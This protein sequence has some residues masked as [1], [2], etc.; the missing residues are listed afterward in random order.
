MFLPPTELSLAKAYIFGDIDLVGDIEAATAV[1]DDIVAR[2]DSLGKWVKIA[3]HVMSALLTLPRPRDTDGVGRRLDAAVGYRHRHSQERDARAVRFH[4]DVGN[5]FYKLWLDKRMVYSCA[6]FQ[7]GDESLD[8]AQT[9]KL[10]Y[11]CRKLDLQAGDHLLDIGCGWGGLITFAAAHYGVNALGVTLSPPQ[12][13]IARERI[14]ATGLS[15][16]CRV[17]VRDYR[18]LRKGRQFNKIVSVGMVEHVGEDHLPEY[19]DSI[20]GMLEP[21]GLFLNHGIVTIDGARSVPRLTR[22][23]NRLWRRGAF[24]ENYVFPD[25]QLVPLAGVLRQA[26]RFGFEV[27]DVESLREHYALTLRHWVHRL[28]QAHDIV[29]RIVGEATY[30]VWRL[31]MGASAHGFATGRIGIAQTLLSKPLFGRAGLPLTR[32]RWYSARQ[33]AVTTGNGR[34]HGDAH[35]S[36]DPR[37]RGDDNE[38]W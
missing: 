35:Y 31:Y 7:H 27:R 32:H 14:E 10:D 22:L 16:R 17:E 26:E 20:Y 38:A 3:S 6:Y 24:I 36:L 25:G 21:G 11:L 30:R 1:C 28:E 23:R 12:A 8:E 4:Y 34:I 13:K 33:S 37:F 9:A 19:F 2:H 18:T 15:D 5:S 29:R